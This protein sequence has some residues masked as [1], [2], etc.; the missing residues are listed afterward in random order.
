MD[1]PKNS[2]L[3]YSVLFENMDIPLSTLTDEN[4]LDVQQTF[5]KGQKYLVLIYKDRTPF[6]ESLRD[7][8]RFNNMKD[9]E[10]LI[11]SFD[12]SKVVDATNNTDANGV[13]PSKHY[14][15]PIVRVNFTC[16]FL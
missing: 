15:G 13:V 8:Q 9:D 10:E 16:P 5:L 4:L 1:V 2:V 3:L 6:V 14:F 7:N 11:S 12:R